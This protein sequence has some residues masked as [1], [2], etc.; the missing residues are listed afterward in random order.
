MFYYLALGLSSF[1]SFLMLKW[2][3]QQ[4]YGLA[5]NSVSLLNT[6]ISSED[7]NQ[8]LEAMQKDTSSLFFSLLSFIALLIFALLI[9]L[10]PAIIFGFWQAGE[11][12]FISPTS[13]QEL[14]SI[15]IGAS[16]V[17]IPISPKNTSSYS[18][19]SQ[20]LHRLAL[21]NYNIGFQ[22][23]TRE[24][25]QKMKQGIQLKDEFI[26][27]SGLARA[28]TTSLMNHLLKVEGFA[29]LSYANMPFLLAPNTWRK[30]YHPTDKSTKERSHK[31]GIKIG[32]N[33]NEALE[34]YFF[35]AL[36]QDAYLKA[37]RLK[38]YTLSEDEYRDYLS[39]Q[40]LIR[41]SP[42]EIYLAKNNNFLLRY[43]SMRAYNPNFLLVVL[44]RNPL[45]H[46]TSL[47]EKHMYYSELQKE[48]PFVEEYMNWLGHHEFG[49]SQKAFQFGEKEPPQGDK[50]S[51]DY[52]LKIWLNYYQYALQ[53]EDAQSLFIPYE[54][55]CANPQENL[56][57]IL[58]KLDNG[59]RSPTV[60]P[61]SN[62]RKHSDKHPYQEA[63]MQEAMKLYQSLL[64][65]AEL[66][67]SKPY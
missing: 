7:D 56:E 20:L 54:S 50:N 32:L 41:K 8:K 60:E 17:F 2:R 45:L 61:F 10:T 48:D 31:D 59:L 64:S 46:A 12:A 26:I 65:K 62:L 1:L 49:L 66:Q 5:E 6:L 4:F 14:L 55:L 58:G 37:D 29:S 57:S 47:L 22:L 36:S 40:S 53:I 11:W 9:I 44:F 27:V 3:R 43:K 18:E 34:E 15:S 28:G 13:W 63:L 52:W 67:F 23:F 38:E 30:I 19:L 39:Y 16:L 24:V 35:K 42:T 33:S 21:N 51:L 25:K